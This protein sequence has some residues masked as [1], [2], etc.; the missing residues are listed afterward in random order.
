M[1]ND[2]LMVSPCADMA[3]KKIVRKYKEIEPDRILDIE[4]YGILPIGTDE[5]F[6]LI[7]NSNTHYVSNYGRC[8]AKMEPHWTSEKH[9]MY[10][11][12]LVILHLMSGK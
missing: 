6:V 2:D 11:T 9:R 5:I 7:E 8:I 12:L 1:Y 3:N 4:K 10:F